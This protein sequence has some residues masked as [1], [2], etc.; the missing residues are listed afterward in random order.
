M[1]TCVFIA[2]VMSKSDL[3]RK[4]LSVVIG[5]NAYVKKITTIVYCVKSALLHFDSIVEKSL[6]NTFPALQLYD[7]IANNGHQHFFLNA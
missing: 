1:Q 5:N 6:F 2:I 4:S 7:Y 3:N